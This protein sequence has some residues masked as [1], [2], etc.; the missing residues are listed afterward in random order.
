MDTSN[1]SNALLFIKM[2]KLKKKTNKRIN[3]IQTCIAPKL[4]TIHD[5]NIIF[6]QYGYPIHCQVA[7]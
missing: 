2:K 5:N 3:M 4:S 6:Q 7:I 1:I